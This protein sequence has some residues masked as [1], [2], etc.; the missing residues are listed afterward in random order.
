[1]KYTR[2]P[3]PKNLTNVIQF[4]WDFEGD[5]SEQSAY[6]HAIAASINPKLAF[7]YKAGMK[8]IKDGKYETL[9]TSGFQCQTSTFYEVLANQRIGV[10]GVSLHPYTIPL[11]FNI[12]SSALSNAN[13]EIS[14]LLGNEGRVLQDRIFS[15]NTTAERIDSITAFVET[16]LKEPDYRTANVLLSIQ[17]ILANK[18][19]CNTQELA[20]TNFLSQRQF[21]RRF[22]DL[23]GFSPKIFSKIVR[24]EEC[25]SKAYEAHHSLTDLSLAAGYYDQSHMIRDFKEFTGKNPTDYLVENHSIFLG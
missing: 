17:Y 3:P 21:E 2:I 7:Q 16:K 23:T 20:E 6:T 19:K 5:F 4:F 1:M 13:V 15:C 9:F 25:V 12:P 10:F 18:G 14:D 22:K 8:T 24:F 11:L